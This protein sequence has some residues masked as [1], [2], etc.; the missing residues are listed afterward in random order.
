MVRRVQMKVLLSEQP[1][2]S[3]V[4]AQEISRGVADVNVLEDM[5]CE[6]RDSWRGHP[7]EK[8]TQSFLYVNRGRSLTVPRKHGV[9]QD[10]QQA[11]KQ[12]SKPASKQASKSPPCH[13]VS[14]RL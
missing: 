8:K 6:R 11:S 1:K 9:C 10:N 12:A 13:V 5:K 4:C 3:A 7:L 2:K 14:T